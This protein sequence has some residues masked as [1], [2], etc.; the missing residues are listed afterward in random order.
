MTLDRFE[1]AWRADESTTG[2]EELMRTLRQIERE[3]RFQ[4]VL[5]YVCA[6]ITLGMAVLI[7]SKVPDGNFPNGLLR[8]AATL[9]AFCGGSILFRRGSSAGAV[10]RVFL[11]Q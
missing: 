5:Q 7:R 3:G 4:T 9:A 10:F 8:M 1:E 6:G 2:P 11:R